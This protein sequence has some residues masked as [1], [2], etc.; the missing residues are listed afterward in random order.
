MAGVGNMS[1]NYLVLKKKDGVCQ[2][3]IIVNLK[4][5]P[6]VEAETT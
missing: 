6:I 4:E 3:D 2:K 1:L 5:L